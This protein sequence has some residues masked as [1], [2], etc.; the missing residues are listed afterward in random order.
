MLQSRNTGH[1]LVGQA[2]TAIAKARTVGAPRLFRL[3]TDNSKLFVKSKNEWTKAKAKER[4]TFYGTLYPNGM[5]TL[6]NGS[7]FPHGMAE[8]R[9]HFEK[10][11]LCE[12][13]WLDEEEV[14]S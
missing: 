5:A 13:V 8:V 3:T 4:I 11:G 12:I 6:D 14:K 7:C 9:D 10:A 1:A 2:L